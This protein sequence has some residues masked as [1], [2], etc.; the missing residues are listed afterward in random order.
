M[1]LLVP[2]T[3]FFKKQTKESIK[4]DVKKTERNSFRAI[5]RYSVYLFMQYWKLGK[6]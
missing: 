3:E 5:F 1:T 4:L 6:I 2:F